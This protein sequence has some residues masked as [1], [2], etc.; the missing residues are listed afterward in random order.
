[1]FLGKSC[2]LLR[3]FAFGQ[4]LSLGG[5]FLSGSLFFNE[6]FGFHGLSSGDLR[7]FAFGLFLGLGGG[8]LGGGLFFGEAFGFLGLC[9][10]DL[11]SLFFSQRLRFGLG[12]GE[13]SGQTFGDG[14]FLGG[15]FLGFCLFLGKTCGF[16]LGQSLSLGGFLFSE[17]PGF[18]S[19]SGGLHGFKFEQSLRLG[20]RSGFFLSDACRLLGF[21][22]GDTCRFF[23]RERLGLG[24]LP[25]CDVGGGL[26]LH[27]GS[28]L[29]DVID[30]LLAKFSAGGAQL[31][32]GF[33]EHTGLDLKRLE[34]LGGVGKK[35]EE[36]R[37]E[38]GGH[39][40]G[41]KMGGDEWSEM[42][43]CKAEMRRGKPT[44][45]DPPRP[46]TLTRPRFTIFASTSKNPIP[47]Q[48]CVWNAPESSMLAQRFVR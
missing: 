6:T 43:L 44:A 26:R 9:R 35:G 47:R 3:S 39:C 23:F 27:G 2:G 13:H 4:F 7:G 24:F 37:V 19:G 33:I 10:S 21:Q 12:S 41:R 38:L 36:F 48:A 46:P 16:L 17:F 20:G 5:G 22:R 30:Q 1:M 15:N 45:G 28:E 8:F 32:R 42:G 11:R 14:A 40:D 31:R 25:G 34:F 18:D 29:R